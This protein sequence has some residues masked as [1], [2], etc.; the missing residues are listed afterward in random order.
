MK[1]FRLLILTPTALPAVTGNAM[2]AERWRRCLVG[3]GLDVRLLPTEGLAPGD[4][5]GEIIRF[6]PDLVHVHNAYRAGELLLVEAVAHLVEDGRLHD[7]SLRENFVLRSPISGIVS[8]RKAEAEA[9]RAVDVFR[10]APGI[11]FY[12]LNRSTATIEIL[13]AIR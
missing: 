6:R 3:M 11:H 10:G 9:E 2:T 12:T 1:P 4:L 5:K 7:A 8:E 13:E